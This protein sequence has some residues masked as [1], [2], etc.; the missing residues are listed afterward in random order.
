MIKIKYTIVDKTYTK[1]ETSGHAEYADHGS[2]II[3][4]GVST[5]MVGLMNALDEIEG[6]E[7]KE[8]KNHIVIINETSS[9][10]ANN[11]LELALIQLKTIEESYGEFIKVE[12]K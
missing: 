3:C 10:K 8:K 4:A 9:R 5:V 11:Y 7:I 12:R 1:L 6:V 2:D